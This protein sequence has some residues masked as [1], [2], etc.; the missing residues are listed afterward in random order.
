MANIT[1]TI[2]DANL[3]RIID[4]F[5]VRYDYTRNLLVGETKAQF[6]KRMLIAMI[7]QSVIDSEADAARRTASSTVTG[8]VEGIGIN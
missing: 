5:A 3:P 7:K 8:E 1:I 4:G 6:A 2:P